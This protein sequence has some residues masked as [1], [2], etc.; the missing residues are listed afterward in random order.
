M[1]E[2]RGQKKKRE[3]EAR[4][5]QFE[6]AGATPSQEE[7]GTYSQSHP[8]SESDSDSEIYQ[9]FCNFMKKFTQEQK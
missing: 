3:E 5:L 2:M 6:Q 8:A 1:V 7:G 4:F 9:Q